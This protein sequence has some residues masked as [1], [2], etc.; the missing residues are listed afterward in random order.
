MC[1]CCRCPS[2]CAS[3]Y[4]PLGGGEVPETTVELTPITDADVPAVADF[5]HVNLNIRVPP[6]TW[7]Y[8]MS[9]PWKTEAPNHG[10]MLRDGQRVVG[11]SWPYSERTVAG[12]RNGSATWPP[13]ASAGVPVPQRPAAQGVAGPGWLPLH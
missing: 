2:I 13:G 9:A 6:P 1:S 8:A 12:R 7:V 10:F 5:L 3:R 4:R 11:V